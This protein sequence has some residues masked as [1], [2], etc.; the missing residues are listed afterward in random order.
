M[1]LRGYL[2]VLLK[3]WR[4]LTACTLLVLNAAAALTYLQ[5]PL[6]AANAT[7]FVSIASSG[8]G[9]LDLPELAVR[10]AAGEVLRRGGQEPRGPPAG[11]RP[12]RPADDRARPAA[13]PS[14]RT[15]RSTRCSSP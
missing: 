1:T 6:Y 4:I 8:R 10:H 12:A 5:T 15:T 11:H 3:R 7:S 9:Q 13:A 14:A 2:Q